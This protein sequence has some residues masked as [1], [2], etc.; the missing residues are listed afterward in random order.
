MD[1]TNG[2]RWDDADDRDYVRA[3]RDAARDYI[4]S[5]REG[6]VVAMLD[7]VNL[8]SVVVVGGVPV[9]LPVG[10]RVVPVEG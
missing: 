6:R 3:I 9:V 5:Q 7:A 2:K 10:A 4:A 1:L 8:R